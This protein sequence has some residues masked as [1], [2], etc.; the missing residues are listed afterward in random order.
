MRLMRIRNDLVGPFL[1]SELF[2]VP[3][4]TTVH[5][6]GKKMSTVGQ[7]SCNMRNKMSNKSVGKSEYAVAATP[8]V[9]TSILLV[10]TSN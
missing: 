10:P 8:G 3:P 5:E 6:R 7:C 1:E 4:A 9:C 2:S